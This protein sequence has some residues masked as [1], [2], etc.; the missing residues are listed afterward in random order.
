VHASLLPLEW[1]TFSSNSQQ[2]E[3]RKMEI[4]KE[5]EK[6]KNIKVRKEIVTGRGRSWGRKRHKY[7]YLSLLATKSFSC[8]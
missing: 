4:N 8:Y 3:C 5:T 2:F 1:T 6:K 7:K